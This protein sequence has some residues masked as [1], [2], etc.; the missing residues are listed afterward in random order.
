[1][2]SDDEMERVIAQM[3]RMGYGQGPEED[4]ANDAARPRLLGD[5]G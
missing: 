1:M 2:L 3:T 4:G 5:K